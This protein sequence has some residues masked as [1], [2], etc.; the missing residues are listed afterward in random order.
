LE[1]YLIK[2]FRYGFLRADGSGK[3]SG[4]MQKFQQWGLCVFRISEEIK[5]SF[6][7]RERYYRCCWLGCK[8]GK[9]S[10]EAGVALV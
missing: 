10:R 7:L 3:A 5:D 9:Y 4:T 8:C 6:L 2:Y 1:I